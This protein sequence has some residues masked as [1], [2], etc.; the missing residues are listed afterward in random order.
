[1]NAQGWSED[2]KNNHHEAFYHRYTRAE[3]AGKVT[4]AGFVVERVTHANSFGSLVA[5]VRK[6][7]KPKSTEHGHPHGGDTGLAI[8]VPKSKALNAM[9]YR[10]MQAEAGYLA[11]PSRTLPFGHSLLCLARK[12]T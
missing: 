11:K 6:R 3:L 5:E 12:P 7:L 9:L 4:A 10:V 1:T 8:Q 2:I